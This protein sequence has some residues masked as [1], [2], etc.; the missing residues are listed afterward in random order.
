MA[1]PTLGLPLLVVSVAV[2][3][4]LAGTSIFDGIEPRKK[5]YVSSHRQQMATH[6][7]PDRNESLM[8][9]TTGARVLITDLAADKL[10]EKASKHGTERYRKWCGGKD[11]W[12]D[13]AERLH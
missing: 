2:V 3:E 5:F 10:L 1:K 9:E 6:P 8:H 12:D 13:Y 7:N 4:T 11:G